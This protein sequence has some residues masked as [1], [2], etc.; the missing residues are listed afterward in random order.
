M[1]S[2]TKQIYYIAQLILK[3]S[4]KAIGV[5]LF[6]VGILFIIAGIAGPILRLATN[7]SIHMSYLITS[8]GGVVIGI[9]FMQGGI[10]F[11]RK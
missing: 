6:I 2:N 4:M 7:E 11:L 5:I 8:A 1:L 3:I 10:S 9:L